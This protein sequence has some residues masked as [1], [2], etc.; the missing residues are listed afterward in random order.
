MGE[1]IDYSAFM[2]VIA[3]LP[4]RRIALLLDLV[5]E[6]QGE[7]PGN[8]SSTW[9]ARRLASRPAFAGWFV[10]L[11]LQLGDVP[12]ERLFRGFLA[13]VL[14]R[15]GERRRRFAREHG[16]PPPAMI[17]VCPTMGCTLSCGGCVMRSYAAGG[18]M[19][20][21]LLERVL[22]EA[23]EMGT[24]LVCVSGGEPLTY[25]HLLRVAG[26]RNDLVFLV[27]TNGTLLSPETVERMARVGNVWP[28]IGVDGLEEETDARRGRGI[29][30]GIVR[31][32]DLLREAGV[33][34]GFNV[35][36]TRTNC[37]R[38]ASDGF[39][40]YYLER[41]ALLGCLNQYLPVGRDADLD[42]MCTAEQR[43]EAR[44]KVVEWQGTRPILVADLLTDGACLG[45][46]TAGSRNVHVGADGRV[47]PCS[48]V[49]FSTMS[50]RDRSLVEV[51]ASDLMRRVR[52]MQPCDRN[53]LR[54]C[55]IIDHPAVL[56]TLVE[57]SEAEPAFEGA[58]RLVR[59]GVTRR[60]LDAYARRWAEI[61][62]RAWRGPDYERGHNVIV[63]LAGRI[64]VHAAFPERME[65]AR[66]VGAEL[67]A[68]GIGIVPGR[69]PGGAGLPAPIVQAEPV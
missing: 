55:M 4:G 68:R 33:L 54:P 17:T 8:V 59:D 37:E 63:P 50:L 27:Q 32:M 48:F 47:Q 62:D 24:R 67:Q 3:R 39:L 10:R 25:P 45:G 38:V 18:P 29:H 34:F 36:L 52:D 44:R 20:P 61:A 13:S 16:F 23:S 30:A 19:D 56:R 43:E 66:V 42:L 69:R 53:L 46:C 35:M 58:D 31:A 65:Q 15:G 9:L 49:P 12:F 26:E 6:L 40:E 57:R 1:S 14:I 2:E 5:Q 28:V 60:R 64:D 11:G 21:G 7:I 41:G 51:L 22:V